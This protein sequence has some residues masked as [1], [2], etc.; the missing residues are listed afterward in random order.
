MT[1]TENA[2]ISSVLISL[3]ETNT[4]NVSTTET[5]VASLTIRVR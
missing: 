3:R 2:R 4:L 1:A 5:S